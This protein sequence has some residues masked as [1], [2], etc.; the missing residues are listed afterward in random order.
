[1]Q[2]GPFKLLPAIPLLLLQC[3]S[4][5]GQAPRSRG[6]QGASLT[7]LYCFF[8]LNMALGRRLGFCVCLNTAHL[9]LL[10]E[11]DHRKH[12]NP[13]PS[14]VSLLTLQE[15]QKDTGVGGGG[16]CCLNATCQFLQAG[17]ASGKCLNTAC[18][19]FDLAA[20]SER[21][22]CSFSNQLA[23]R[24]VYSRCKGLGGIF[25]SFSSLASC[26]SLPANS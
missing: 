17:K 4:D 16:R 6:I 14:P 24:V 12:L 3:T 1:M 23:Q 19:P 22:F 5:S 26:Y 9:L 7:G 21:Q 18:K 15:D 2:H 13:L 25:S 8:K 11:G 20:G 10:L